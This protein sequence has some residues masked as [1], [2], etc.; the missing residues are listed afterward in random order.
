MLLQLGVLGGISSRDPVI[1]CLSVSL[2]T[3]IFLVGRKPAIA[4]ISSRSRA[5]SDSESLVYCG[6]EQKVEVEGAARILAEHF[7]PDELYRVMV[8][9]VRRKQ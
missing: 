4:P 3:E 9:T 5:A 2:L 6:Q 1:A 7:D 8:E